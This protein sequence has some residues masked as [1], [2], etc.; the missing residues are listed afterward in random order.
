MLFLDLKIKIFSWIQDFNFFICLEILDN[1]EF[2]AIFRGK[3]IKKW[4][5]QGFK[6]NPDNILQIISILFFNSYV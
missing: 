6:K 5:I 1:F 3:S 2:W 4:L